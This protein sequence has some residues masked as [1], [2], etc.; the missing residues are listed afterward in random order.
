MLRTERFDDG[1]GWF[2]E[3]Y[4]R[5]DAAAAGVDA[6]F[7]QDN[8]SLS[9]DAG[10]VRGLHFQTGPHAQGKLIRVIRGAIFDV[11]V[12]VRQS[13]PHLGRHFTESLSADDGRQLWM[14]PGFAHGFCSLE[15]DTLVAYKVTDFYAAASD[16]AIL[17]ND[18]DLG[19]AWPEEADPAT[20]SPRDATAPTLSE[21]AAAGDLL[22]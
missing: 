19:I 22:P 10:T 2:C 12:D 15:P 20:L 7:V 16:R 21:L 4:N 18:A 6:E 13:S 11:G 8:E 3:T 9:R 14:P 5:R 1:R 17:W